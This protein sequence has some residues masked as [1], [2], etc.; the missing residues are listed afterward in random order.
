MSKVITKFFTKKISDAVKNDLVSNVYYFA[1]SKYSTWPD[2]NN[3][4]I[5]YDTRKNILDFQKI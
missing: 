5:A 3:P 1:L 2:E 4:T